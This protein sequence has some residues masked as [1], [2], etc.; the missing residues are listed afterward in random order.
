[1]IETAQLLHN[2]STPPKS[3]VKYNG[4]R[5]ISKATDIHGTGLGWL[6]VS[7]NGAFGSFITFR[8]PE[9]LR[10]CGAKTILERLGLKSGSEPERTLLDLIEARARELV[11]PDA[12][13]VIPTKIDRPCPWP[14]PLAILAVITKSSASIWLRS[15]SPRLS[16]LRKTPAIS[17]LVPP[18]FAEQIEEPPS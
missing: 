3:V 13:V 14:D 4:L 7:N 11:L 18:V 17:L 1:M 12:C 16:V 10:L 6:A 5:K 2:M 8:M 15:K 9:N